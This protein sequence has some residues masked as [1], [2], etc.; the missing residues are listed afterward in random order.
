MSMMEWLERARID[1]LLMMIPMSKRERDFRDETRMMKV[2]F[3]G[4]HDMDKV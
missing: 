3:F 4:R 2:G 1:M